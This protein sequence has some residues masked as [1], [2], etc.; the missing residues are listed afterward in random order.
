MHHDIS[1]K[2]SPMTKGIPEILGGVVDSLFLLAPRIIAAC[3]PPVATALS[4]FE[5]TLDHLFREGYVSDPKTFFSFPAGAPAHRVLEES[6]Y[7]DGSYELICFESGYMP[8]IPML[9]ERYLSHAANATGYIARWTHRRPAPRTVLCLH[10]YLLGDPSQAHRMFKVR[11]LF[12]MG[13]DV[14]LLSGLP[15]PPGC[16]GKILFNTVPLVIHD[17]QIT[18][19][20]S[21]TL[22]GRLA[23]PLHS[24]DIVLRDTVAVMIHDTQIALRFR[25][26]LL[27][28]LAIQF[29]GLGVI[30]PD[31]FAD[32]IFD[33]EIVLGSCVS[34]VRRFAVPFDGFSIVT[35]NPL[36]LFIHQPE[37]KL[38]F[39]I[40]LF[41]RF[42]KPVDS[43][44][45]ILR[46]AI[47]GLIH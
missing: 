8:R 46:N 30:L 28:S 41:G 37:M 3:R 9:R 5:S 32:F 26:S 42:T 15:I 4:A 1:M 27:S 25:V 2:G 43:F 14:A 13:L 20:L 29:Y 35:A 7:G 47:S 31:P 24:F 38:R 34:M 40:F 12:D 17:T 16:F 6:P 45:I 11:R 10:G 19:R 39:R 21:V 33:R 22:L 36:A 44:G 23:V 18:L